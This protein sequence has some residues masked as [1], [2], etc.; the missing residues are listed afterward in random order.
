LPDSGGKTFLEVT[1]KNI[2]AT[3]GKPLT[4]RGSGRGNG[5]GTALLT[6]RSSIAVIH[7][8]SSSKVTALSS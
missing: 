5:K 7:H 2:F 6:V 4:I 1:E 3:Q 8:A